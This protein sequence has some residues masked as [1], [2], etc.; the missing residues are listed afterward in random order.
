MRTITNALLV[1]LAIGGFVTL[2]VLGIAGLV[3]KPF[4]LLGSFLYENQN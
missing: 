4:V 2:F 1:G 3:L